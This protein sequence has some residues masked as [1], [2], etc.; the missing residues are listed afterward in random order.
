MEPTK[1]NDKLLS[2]P[3]VI[4]TPHTAGST[5]DTYERVINICINNIKSMLTK[6]KCN[7]R[8]F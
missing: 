5:K 3:N 1:K 6:K 7:F 4:C 2:L 8:V